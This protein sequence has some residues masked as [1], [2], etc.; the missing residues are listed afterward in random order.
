M[1]LA[2]AV[3]AALMCSV[4][5]PTLRADGAPT[6]TIVDI[7]GVNI[8]LGGET[9]NFFMQENLTTGV[10]ELSTMSLIGGLDCFSYAACG[11]DGVTFQIGVFDYSLE[12]GGPIVA[13]WPNPGVYPAVVVDIT[14]APE[15]PCSFAG[16]EGFVLGNDYPGSGEVIISDA[17][18]QSVPEP[19]IWTLLLAGIAPLGLLQF[20]RVANPS[21]LNA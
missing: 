15:A 14:C 8:I 10:V 20:G 2:M 4:F 19:G 17:P 12:I 5:A 11:S 18:S 9:F 21:T 7:N 16:I 3:L 6:D 13:Q 1:K